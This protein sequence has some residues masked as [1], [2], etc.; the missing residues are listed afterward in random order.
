MS[1]VI[2]M[3]SSASSSLELP[4]LNDTP[5]YKASVLK[6]LKNKKVLSEWLNDPPPPSLPLANKKLL[7]TQVYKTLESCW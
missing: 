1:K 6:V 5:I 2:L 7:E 3:P 4:P